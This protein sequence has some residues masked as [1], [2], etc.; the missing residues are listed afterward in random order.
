[1]ANT[2]TGMMKFFYKNFI[3]LY[4]NTVTV[5]TGSSSVANLYDNDPTT[6]WLSSGSSDATTETIIILFTS[7]QTINR[8]MALNMNWKNYT[9]KY[10]TD[11]VTY[12]DFTSVY[13]LKADTNAASS[14]V[15]TTETNS[16]RYWEF[17]SVSAL[18][19]KFTINT[20]QTANAEK[21]LYELFIGLEIGTLDNDLACAPNSFRSAFKNGAKYLDLS[22]LGKKRFERGKKWYA[23]VKIKNMWEVADKTIIAT[24]FSQGEFVISPCGADGTVYTDEGWRLQDLYNVII[25]GELSAN[26]SVGRDT[27]VG[28][29]QDFELDET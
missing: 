14:I 11:G 20:T 9:V 7:A 15:Q 29:D 4:S 25:N 18:S 21:Y 5:S 22:N 10:S 28:L 16:S 6:R 26:F 1:M 13:S 8:I 17:A 19:I 2:I 3:N 12:S 24:L 27:D 23:K